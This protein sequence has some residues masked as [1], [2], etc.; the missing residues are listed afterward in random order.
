MSLGLD[1]GNIRQAWPLRTDHA[2]ARDTGTEW[3]GLSRLHGVLQRSAHVCTVPGRPCQCQAPPAATGDHVGSPRHTA[4]AGPWGLAGNMDRL[5]D[6]FAELHKA[7]PR[8]NIPPAAVLKGQAV[9]LAEG[10]EQGATN[11]QERPV[12]QSRL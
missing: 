8:Q 7:A 4:L 6:P 2:G 5:L 10:Q 3:A 11:T 12:W 9:R 1:G